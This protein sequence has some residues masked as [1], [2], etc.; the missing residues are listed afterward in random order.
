MKVN[1][2]AFRMLY[3]E[4]VKEKSHERDAKTPSKT[5]N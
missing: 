4:G 3:M 2:D 1:R 5:V